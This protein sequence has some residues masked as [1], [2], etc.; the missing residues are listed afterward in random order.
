MRA[1]STRPT[2][3]TRPDAR[4]PTWTWAATAA[5]DALGR[6]T[7]AVDGDGNTT[8]YTYDPQGDVL[9]TAV[10]SAGGTLLRQTTAAYDTYGDVTQAVDGNG[11][12]STFAYDP[13]HDLT[14]AT[15]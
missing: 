14:A 3:T 2:T 7:Q 9:S 8:D 4:W 11:H 6:V 15:D 1:S 10:Y 12:T 5:H 13:R